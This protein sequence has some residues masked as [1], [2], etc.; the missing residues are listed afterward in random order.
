M[1]I[2]PNSGAA[3]LSPHVP[4]DLIAGDAQIRAVSGV[5]PAGS[6]IARGAV[7]G[8]VTATGAWILSLAAAADGS[9]T[10]RGILGEG[11]DGVL[12]ADATRPVYIAGDFNERRITIGAGHDLD[13]VRAAFLGTPLFIQ[14]TVSR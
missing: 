11:T 8:Q 14:T 4:D 2:N 12:A 6:D 9:Q 10:P 13:S 5:I 7:L 1:S 3:P